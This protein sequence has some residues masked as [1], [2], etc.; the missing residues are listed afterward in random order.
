VVRLESL[1]RFV[2]LL[3]PCIVRVV[4]DAGA[5]TVDTGAFTPGVSAF[6]ADKGAFT[7]GAS[8]F[9]A[10]ILDPLR[11]GVLDEFIGTV[12]EFIGTVDEFIGTVDEF[13]GTVDEFIRGAFIGRAA[14][15]FIDGGI[16]D[17]IPTIDLS[18]FNM[19]ILNIPSI[20]FYD[21]SSS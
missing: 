16:V 3:P 2:C 21:V 12:D 5:F 10:L 13:I 20:S 19:L 4:N 1:E 7:R 18:E 15:A 17:V 9:S 6:S 8:A 11:T 14:D